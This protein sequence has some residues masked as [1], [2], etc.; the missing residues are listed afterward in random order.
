MHNVI[1]RDCAKKSADAIANKNPTGSLVGLISAHTPYARP[2]PASTRATSAG[3]A[4]HFPEAKT[5]SATVAED[6]FLL[7]GKK[8]DKTAR[9]QDGRAI[10]V[11]SS[12]RLAVL[13][14][15]ERKNYE[16]PCCT[17]GA[18]RAGDTRRLRNASRHTGGFRHDRPEHAH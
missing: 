5:V 14:Q 16:T 9:R 3:R 2:R 8:Q 6:G 17:L 13:S 11:R 1:D 10:P 7:G 18:A 4:L 15:T 12:C